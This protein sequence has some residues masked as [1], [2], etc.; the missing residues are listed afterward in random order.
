MRSKTLL[1]FSLQ[2]NTWIKYVMGWKGEVGSLFPLFKDLGKWTGTASQHASLTSGAKHFPF[3]VERDQDL[4]QNISPFQSNFAGIIPCP[5]ESTSQRKIW[6][7]SE[8]PL[9]IS[10][11]IFLACITPKPK[12]GIAATSEESSTPTVIVTAMESAECLSYNSDQLQLLSTGIAESA[13][14]WRKIKT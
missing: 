6:E 8:R 7:G 10:K 11:G 14:S 3:K 2:V 13:A 4:K 9:K 1:S 5:Y 12:P